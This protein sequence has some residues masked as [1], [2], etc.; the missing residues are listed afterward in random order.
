[1]RQIVAPSPNPQDWSASGRIRVEIAD[2]S[3]SQPQDSKP[4][5]QW[6]SIDFDGTQ[7]LFNDSPFMYADGST[8]I[9]VVA[10]GNSQSDKRIINEKAA[11]PATTLCMGLVSPTKALKTDWTHIFVTTQIVS[12]EVKEPFKRCG[13]GRHLQNSQLEGY[14]GAPIVG[15]VNGGNTLPGSSSYT[16]SGKYVHKS[17][18]CGWDIAC[19]L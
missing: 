17:V 13:D 19:L 6:N 4:I 7:Y 16:R 10:S 12:E 11:L 2:M 1:M 3:P 5:P 8:E 14:S 18:L 9:F 15:R